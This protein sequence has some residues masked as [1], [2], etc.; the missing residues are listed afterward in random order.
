[1]SAVRN[2]WKAANGTWLSHPLAAPLST[3]GE[4]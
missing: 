3:A 1:M 4:S 2:A